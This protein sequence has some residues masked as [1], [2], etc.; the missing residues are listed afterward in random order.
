MDGWINKQGSGQDNRAEPVQISCLPLLA[1][2]PLTAALEIPMPWSAFRQ[3][4]LDWLSGTAVIAER[5]A[6]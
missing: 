4:L 3:S 6:R 2:L 5:R 1:R